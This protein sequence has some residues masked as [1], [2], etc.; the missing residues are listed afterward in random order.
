[1]AFAGSRPIGLRLLVARQSTRRSRTWPA[2]A[3][4]MADGLA[5]CPSD[6]ARPGVPQ[7]SNAGA[8]APEP[9]YGSDV[10]IH[11]ADGQILVT[12]GKGL[13]DNAADEPA[14]YALVA[15][16][17]RDDDRLDF[18]TRTAVEQTGQADNAAVGLRHPGS[19]QLHRGEMVIE[20]SSRV[21]SAD[22]QAPYSITQT[23]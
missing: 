5:L 9:A 13:L 17:P 4:D 14:A 3:P 20:S 10:A 6:Q 15:N 7:R 12:T 22:R 19:G 21:V 11:G 18:C 2:S 8:G 1:M 23:R 16:C